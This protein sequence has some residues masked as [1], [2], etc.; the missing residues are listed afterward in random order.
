VKHVTRT[1]KA[2]LGLLA[3]AILASLAG[4]GAAGDHHSED[5]HLEHHVPAHRPHDLAEAVTQ[6]SQRWPRLEAS[7]GLAGEER[8]IALAELA[9]IVRWLPELAADSDMEEG[10]WNR[11]HA[12]SAQLLTRLSPSISRARDQPPLSPWSEV[13]ALVDELAMLAPLASDSTDATQEPAAD[14]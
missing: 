12:I 13:S 6:I 14:E 9:D 5:D 1:A 2:W 3:M 4:C 7:P 11:V 10:P 8:A